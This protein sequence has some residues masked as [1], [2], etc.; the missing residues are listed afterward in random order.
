MQAPVITKQ[1]VTYQYCICCCR[2]STQAFWRGSQNSL[3]VLL[4]SAWLSFWTMMA[5]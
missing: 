1:G 3:R 2:P 5:P 4:A